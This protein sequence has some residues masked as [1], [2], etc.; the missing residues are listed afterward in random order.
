VALL[1]FAFYAFA[2][3]HDWFALSRARLAA[4]EKIRQ[5]GVPRTAIQAGFE[6]DCWTQLQAEGHVNDPRIVTPP[7]AFRPVPSSA[8][9]PKECR[10]WVFSYLTPAVVPQYFLA[11]EPLTCF[12][13][14][15][16]SPV[17]YR[18]WMPPFNRQVF[19]LQRKDVARLKSG[20][21]TSSMAAR[22]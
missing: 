4:A 21:W 14:S 20:I 16:F 18:A 15:V 6:Y 12:A 9:L 7:D 19:V 10:T 3:I 17:T 8:E 1:T 5:T 13:P 2:G 22:Y 11:F